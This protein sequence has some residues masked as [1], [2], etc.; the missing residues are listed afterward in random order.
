MPQTH[1]VQTQR[2]GAVATDAARPRVVVAD[3]LDALGLERL[4]AQAR[5]DVFAGL[6]EPRLIAALQGADAVIVR[7]RSRLTARVL[8][9]APQLRIAARAGVGVD[10]IDVDA[11]TRCGILV[12][13]TPESSTISTAEHTMALLLALARWIP[14]AHASLA[15]GEWRREAFVGIELY[16]KTLG[17]VGLGKI[18]AEV[19]RRAQAFGMRVVAHDPYISEERAAHLGV[20]LAEF[21]HLLASSDVVTLHVPLTPRT[22][23]LLGS[24]QFQRMKPGALL[25]NC[26][27]GGLIDEDALLAALEAGHLGGAALDVF[28]QEP[29][30]RSALLAH[31]RVVATPHLG[32][33]T[34]EAQR[35]VAVEVVEQV[36]AALAGRPVRGAVNAP[37]LLA[38]TWQRLEPYLALARH[39]GTLAQ[40]LTDGQIEAVELRYAGTVA[41]EDPAPLTAA[42]LVGLFSGISARPVNMVNAP[43]LA[44]EHGIRIREVRQ[45]E[46]EDFQ[47]LV[48]VTVR[49]TRAPLGL[50]GTLFGHREPRITRIG[51]YRLDLI[52][53][54]QLLFVW[55]ADRPGMIGRVGT[56]LG[57]H[58]VNI[59][60]MHVGRVTPGGTALMVL[61]VDNEIPA[62]ALVAL[63]QLDGISG[64]RAVRLD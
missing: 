2:D 61:S 58:A 48:T 32:A 38:E 10:N 64:V 26:A 28:E 50:A 45:E 5:V 62:E 33:S 25:V 20:A 43:V 56:I 16:G 15:G 60:N 55:N 63:A 4:R 35:S 42:F 41:R 53:A 13:N 44:R 11:A 24:E 12:L 9:A 27:R 1:G 36:L 59:A 57:A 18:G 8:E 31:P 30:S 22:A 46:S 14:Q 47:S 29:P 37:A 49:T 6:D 23:R 34:R 40:Q 51:D 54:R 39:L 3:G 52:P 21:D 17:V 7:S 19:A